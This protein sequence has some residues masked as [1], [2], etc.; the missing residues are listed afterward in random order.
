MGT[1]F[2]VVSL[3]RS[4]TSVECKVLVLVFMDA[5]DVVEVG[6]FEIDDPL[7]SKRRRLGNPKRPYV[8]PTHGI[9]S[10]LPLCRLFGIP[11]VFLD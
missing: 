4:L 8:N 3:V 6:S 2:I 7:K 10:N 5:K 11:G 1:P 9:I